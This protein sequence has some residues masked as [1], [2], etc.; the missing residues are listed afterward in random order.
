MKFT[1][2][3]LKAVNMGHSEFRGLCDCIL[4]NFL[5]NLRKNSC[6]KS[7]FPK[8]HHLFLHC[9]CFLAAGCSTGVNFKRLFFIINLEDQGH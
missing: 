7:E 9:P 8:E 3:G 5:T 6:V 4:I 2:A 1:L